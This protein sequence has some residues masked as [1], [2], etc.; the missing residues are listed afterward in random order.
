MLARGHTYG[1]WGYDGTSVNGTELYM[2]GTNSMN[3][4]WAWLLVEQDEAFLSLTNVGGD[5]GQT[6]SLAALYSTAGYVDL[7]HGL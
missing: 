3:H 7:P 1:G 2:S 4:A 6:A 5:A